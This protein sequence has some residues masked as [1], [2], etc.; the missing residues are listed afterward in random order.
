M[1]RGYE[2]RGGGGDL[3]SHGVDAPTASGALNGIDRG[4]AEAAAARRGRESAKAAGLEPEVRSGPKAERF[5]SPDAAASAFIAA[6]RAG[7][8]A[9]LQSI[10]GAPEELVSSGDPVA[11]RALIEHFLHE[12]D[13]R[14][15]LDGAEAGMVT[16][17]VGN[18]AW[19][20]AVPIVQ[21]NEGFYF[22]SAAGADEVVF[23]RLGRNELATIEVCRGYVASQ[24]EYAATGH[25]GEPAGV[26]AQALMSD[27][28]RQNG[29][30]WPAAAD[31]LRSPAGPLLAA[32]VEQGYSP[33][34]AGRSTPYHGYFYKPLRAQG[35]NARGGAKSYIGRDGKQ[36]D[37]FALLA[38]P[39]YYGRSGVMSFIV[40]QDGK[41]YEK[42]LGKKTMETV[43]ELR[44]FD[45]QGWSVVQ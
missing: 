16:L 43:R 41:V 35:A 3:T 24:E 12:Y 34:T 17:S 7:D 19:P 32:A 31:A 33:D 18:G 22:N 30:Y 9:R 26:Y 13:T 4:E 36:R 8:E 39:A 5:P 1:D 44:E 25:D 37:G 21:D 2:S 20:F 27:P 11:D 14:H 15:S 29:L 45:P 10:F 38:Y 28:G 42:D 6:L 40:N 23:R